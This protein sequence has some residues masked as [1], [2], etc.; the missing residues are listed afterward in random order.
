MQRRLSLLV[1]GMNVCSGVQQQFGDIP[2]SPVTSPVQQRQPLVVWCIQRPAF[3]FQALSQLRQVVLFDP[4]EGIFAFVGD[5]R[6][7]VTVL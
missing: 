1:L 3:G 6:F 7:L 2:V 5:G 4:V